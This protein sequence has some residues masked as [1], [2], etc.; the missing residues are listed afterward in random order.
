MTAYSTE[1]PRGIAPT[2]KRNLMD[3]L[4]TLN[5]QIGTAEQRLECSCPEK[6]Q[7]VLIVGKVDSLIKI[8]DSMVIRL[9]RVNDALEGLYLPASCHF[10]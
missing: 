10:R 7:N 3:A 6:E 1:E 4:T 8:V 5:E 2:P 9:R